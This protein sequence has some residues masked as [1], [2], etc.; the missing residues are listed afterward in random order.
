MNP[1]TFTWDKIL[2]NLMGVKQYFFWVSKMTSRIK[3]AIS[4]LLQTINIHIFLAFSLFFLTIGIR[5]RHWLILSIL[6]L[7]FTSFLRE[8]SDF[9]FE[10]HYTF[11]TDW[12]VL[13]ASER[14]LQFL[15]LFI[16][17]VRP[18]TIMNNI[19]LCTKM[20]HTFYN[21]DDCVVFV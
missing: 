4:M 8:G 18:H 21:P 1:S 10:K 7:L 19:H 14:T 3:C 15:T 9:K 6:F 2:N 12:M 11:L 16:I 5:S 17:T 13:K 20:E